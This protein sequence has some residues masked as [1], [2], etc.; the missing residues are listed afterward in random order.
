VLVRIL[1]TKT[2]PV[3]INRKITRLVRKETSSLQPVTF[4]MPT[5]EE[6]ELAVRVYDLRTSGTQL[7]LVPDPHASVTAKVHETA[8]VYAVAIKIAENYHQNPL[9][10]RRALGSVYPQGEV[11]VNHVPALM[12]QAE[13]VAFNH[14]EEKE[15]TVRDVLALIHTH[16]SRGGPLFEE[17]NGQLFHTL[18]LSHSTLER[19]RRH[20]LLMH[21][22]G[23][24]DVRDSVS[25]QDVHEVSFHYDPYNF[26]SKNEREFFVD[27]LEQL[28]SNPKDIEGFFFTGGLAHHEKTDFW[29]WYRGMDGRF[30]RYFPDFVLLKKTGECFIVEIKSERDRGAPDVENKAKAVQRLVDVQPE[31][32]RYHVVYTREDRQPVQEWASSE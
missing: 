10:V 12:R 1:K 32:L 3:E 2:P 11:P 19:I 16:D 5:T 18:R 8:S 20:S 17:R 6:A 28:N 25:R 29:F 24:S 7:M 9:S 30:H 21:K 31:K 15:D 26:G 23:E 14:Y 13:K 27:I 4:K 22:Q